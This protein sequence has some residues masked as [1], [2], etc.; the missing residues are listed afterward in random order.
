M[1]Y[2]DE[3]GIRRIM[4]LNYMWRVSKTLYAYYRSSDCEATA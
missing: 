3:G 1:L 4:V 2:T